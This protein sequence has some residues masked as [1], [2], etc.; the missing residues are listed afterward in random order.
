[1]PRLTM[2]EIDGATHDE[3]LSR[4]EFRNALVAFLDRH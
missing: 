3:T 1:M 4:P 2:D